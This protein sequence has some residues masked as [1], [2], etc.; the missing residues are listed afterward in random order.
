M[1][2][3][4]G[5]SLQK[6]EAEKDWAVSFGDYVDEA[7]LQHTKIQISSTT[8]KSGNLAEIVAQE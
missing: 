2:A 1:G 8:S 5:Q 3:R 6:I 7:M 4:V